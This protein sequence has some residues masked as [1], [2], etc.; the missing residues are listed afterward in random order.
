MYWSPKNPPESY[1]PTNFGR[2]VWMM[3]R[4]VYT[5]LP[6][7]LALSK[8]FDVRD[9]SELSVYPWAKA[10]IDEMLGARNS[11]A[12]EKFLEVCK[13][14][15]HHL[16]R[17][18][19]F[20]IEGKIYFLDFLIP[21][22]RIAIEI[23]GKYH[24]YP[25]RAEYD[26]ERDLR[27]ESIGI[28]TI[29]FTTDQLRDENF[30]KEY[31]LPALQGCGKKKIYKGGESQHQLCLKRAID[32][33]KTCPP[34]SEI[35]L[36]TNRT[37]VVRALSHKKRPK[38]G[39]KDLALLAEFYDIK[40]SRHLSVAVR[41]TGPGKNMRRQDKE[42]SRRNRAYCDKVGAERKEEITI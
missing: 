25:N 15:K 35:E 6:K 21:D 40:T 5:S 26:K 24:Q 4:K 31:F 19:F 13:G 29:R 7:Y 36:Q 3:K 9:Y 12:E 8:Q 20:Q 14:F 39:A 41:Y 37:A 27:F 16:F 33:I 11:P 17:Q 18:V 10:K 1:L 38:E 42:W 2:Q 23:D 28:R 34:K 32:I 30:V 22:K